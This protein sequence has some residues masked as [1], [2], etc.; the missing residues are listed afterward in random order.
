MYLTLNRFLNIITLTKMKSLII[1]RCLCLLAESE[2][3]KIYAYKNRINLGANFK[4]SHFDQSLRQA[5]I[6]I[7]A[8]L[9]VFLCLKFSPYLTL[10]KLKRFETGPCC[11][12]SI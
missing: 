9:K 5:Q 7:L 10:N 6:L 2:R 4:T 3:L 1:R 12:I 8:I 11:I